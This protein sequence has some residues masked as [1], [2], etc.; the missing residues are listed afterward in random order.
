MRAIEFRGKRK[1]TGGWVYGYLYCIP[2][3]Y[4][5][6]RNGYNFIVECA[7]KKL[8]PDPDDFRLVYPDT[9]GEYTGLKDSNGVKIFEGDIVGLPDHEDWNVLI[10][11]DGGFKVRYQD[12]SENWI[13][14][15]TDPGDIMLFG[16]IHDNPELLKEGE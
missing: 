14:E 3:G 8:L 9:V 1:D 15:L 10:C 13:S 6:P 4:E 11:W 2:F 5:N 12:G 7:P 16:N